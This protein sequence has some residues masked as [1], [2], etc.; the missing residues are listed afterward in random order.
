M[1]EPAKQMSFRATVLEEDGEWI[2]H[3]L[4]LDIVSTGASADAAMDQLAEAI[5]TQLWYARE[6]DN[7]EHLFRPAP[8][9]AWKKLGQILK[10]PHT[11]VVRSID[12]SGPSEER[13]EVQL[14]AA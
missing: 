6:N 5:G 10:G 3:C 1:A 8:D 2:A 14:K 13:L 4:D 12:T 9:E 7:Y 11:T